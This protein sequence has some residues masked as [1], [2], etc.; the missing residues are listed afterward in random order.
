MRKHMLVPDRHDDTATW[1]KVI[2]MPHVT[3]AHIDALCA[4]IASE[5]EGQAH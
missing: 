2:V 4:D 3:D 5:S 1:A